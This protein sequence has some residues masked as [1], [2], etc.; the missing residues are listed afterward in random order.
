MKRLFLAVKIHANDRFTELY[1]NLCKE[2][3]QDKIKWVDLNNL[4]LTLKFFGETDESRIIEIDNF[5]QSIV[6]DI[7]AFSF[8]ISGLGIFG[9]KYQPKVIWLGTDQNEVLV[10]LCNKILNELSAIGFER[11][12]QN[13]VPHLTLGRI[14]LIY[15]K[16][17]FNESI[18]KY[19]H[20][21]IQTVNVSEIILFESI[22]QKTGAVYKVVSSYKLGCKKL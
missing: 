20:K 17:K 6:A 11:D 22:L 9:S 3:C 2:C 21:D 15:D 10:N 8:I 12:R 16:P 18:K 5:M 4:H 1:Q 7:R 13:F 14:N 19:N